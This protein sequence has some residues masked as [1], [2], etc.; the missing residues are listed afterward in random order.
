M[1]TIS[2]Q[3]KRVLARTL[4]R[5]LSNSEI[6]AVGGSR[7]YGT[8]HRYT[9][10]VQPGESFFESPSDDYDTDSEWYD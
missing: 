2:E 3:P 4:A 10:V 5:E 6:E 1:E 8:N 7:W 9:W